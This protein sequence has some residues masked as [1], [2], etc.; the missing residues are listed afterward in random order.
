MYGKSCPWRANPHRSQV[1]GKTQFSPMS[2]EI[3]FD[4]DYTN[5]STNTGHGARRCGIS[6]V[7]NSGAGPSTIKQYTRHAQID[8]ST[9]Y[10]ESDEADRM[11]A[12]IVVQGLD[13][14]NTVNVVDDDGYNND[15]DDDQPTQ[16]QN[17]PSQR[18]R[19]PNLSSHNNQSITSP[20][21]K[22]SKSR[23][24]SSTGSRSPASSHSS[25]DSPRR[26]HHGRHPSA[27]R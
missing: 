11:R 7:G 23:N 17:Q 25:Y 22:R 20:N 10:R 13:V 19:N 21:R 9:T 26:H 5:P 15:D 1:I 14:K 16:R 2:K 3:A 4:C 18:G 24:H 6:A 8:Q 27:C 12:A